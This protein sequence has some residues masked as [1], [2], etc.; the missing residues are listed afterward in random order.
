MHCSD[1]TILLLCCYAQQYFVVGT[2]KLVNSRPDATHKNYVLNNA[3]KLL[4]HP[5]LP[6]FKNF[7]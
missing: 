7:F 3:L 6:F 5:K 2:G 1:K 4:G